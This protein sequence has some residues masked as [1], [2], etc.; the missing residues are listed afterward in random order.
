MI[1]QYNNIRMRMV[2]T[3]KVHYE[4]VYNEDNTQYLYTHY[5]IDIQA[6]VNPQLMSYFGG[7]GAGEPTPLPGN[8]APMTIHAIRHA[9]LQPRKQ[10]LIRDEIG[11]VH[12]GTP[13]TDLNMSSDAKNGPCPRS[14]TM[15][16]ISGART[17]MI[18]WTCEGWV[19]EC[20][21]PLDPDNPAAYILSHRWS[22]QVIINEYQLATRYITGR[23]IFDKGLLDTI[24]DKKKRQ[25]D[26]FRNRLLFP[27][28]AA[29]FQRKR[30]EVLQTSDGTELQWRITDEEGMY[31][32]TE[33]KPKGV[34]GA[35]DPWGGGPS[36]TGDG[37]SGILQ[38]DGA[39]SIQAFQPKD[40]EGAALAGYT[41][42][43]I[44]LRAMGSFYA[45]QYTMLQRLIQIAATLTPRTMVVPNPGEEQDTKN[46][47]FFV[48]ASVERS[49][50][51]REKWVR[52]EFQIMCPPVDLAGEFTGNVNLLPITQD[53]F[54]AM[55]NRIKQ[56]GGITPSLVRD[57]GTRGSSPI[58]LM[59][60]EL[61]ESCAGQVEPPTVDLV[62][63]S[64]ASSTNNSSPDYK[65][66]GQTQQVIPQTPSKYDKSQDTYKY[67]Y[68]VYNMKKEERHE[69]GSVAMPKTGP[70]EGEGFGGPYGGGSPGDSPSPE[71]STRTSRPGSRR[72]ITR[73]RGPSVQPLVTN[74][75]SGNYGGSQSGKGTVS[76]A[77]IHLPLTR[78]RYTFTAE[79]LGI[80]PQLPS[81]TPNDSNEYVL[82]RWYISPYYVVPA[83]DGI[84]PVF[85]VDGE[86]VY[87]KKTATSVD[88]IQIPMGKLPFSL[89]GPGELTSISSSVFSDKRIL[90]I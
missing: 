86:F 23:T 73:N 2:K 75:A 71:L 65:S 79:R 39:Q 81:P 20:P 31:V 60:N 30:F 61:A 43:T 35:N 12:L 83:Y 55:N 77:R 50:G 28:V 13:R 25:P 5:L 48:G 70:L 21:F 90:G 40:I 8:S 22:D 34:S 78:I 26:Y 57:K 51:Q 82:L 47:Y 63:D 53:V 36:I 16:N 42:N 52:L 7:D 41:V 33:T 14:C 11:N 19:R 49:L 85:R 87:A 62:E 88:N 69:S 45:H 37:G 29:G 84:T 76:I 64:G 6:I 18:N 15:V 67:P 3:N 74:T 17:V 54:Y 10:L 68:P 72:R 80:P 9:L 46:S 89:F 66:P 4:A 44:Q 56:E 58:V 24:S 59:S 1:Y 27:K 32:L 38:I